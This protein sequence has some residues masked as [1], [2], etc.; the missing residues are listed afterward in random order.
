[1]LSL[2][3]WKSEKAMQ[4]YLL[5]RK[6]VNLFTNSANGHCSVFMHKITKKITTNAPLNGIL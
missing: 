3:G 1:M 5:T 4:T 6:P 2:N